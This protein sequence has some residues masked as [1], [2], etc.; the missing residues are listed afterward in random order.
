[1]SKKAVLLR[2]DYP[3]YVSRFFVFFILVVRVIY[4]RFL[5]TISCRAMTTVFTLMFVEKRYIE[6]LCQ[7]IF[8]SLIKAELQQPFVII[9]RWSEVKS[10]LEA[11]S[12]SSP[13]SRAKVASFPA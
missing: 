13:F 10:K 3:N 2:S 8:T 4:H 7:Q 1:M 11:S 12:T 9:Y 6:R 5:R